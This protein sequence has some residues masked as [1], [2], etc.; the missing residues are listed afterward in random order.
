MTQVGFVLP[1]VLIIALWMAFLVRP[2]LCWPVG[3]V[4]RGF[5]FVLTVVLLLGL[6]LLSLLVLGLFV[7]VVC[8]GTSATVGTRLPSITIQ[9]VNAVAESLRVKA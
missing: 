9:A 7:T 6:V 5:L 3:F 2:V 1:L 4:W 8:R